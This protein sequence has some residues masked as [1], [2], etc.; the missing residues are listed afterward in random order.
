MCLHLH[1]LCDVIK[2]PSDI[3]IFFHIAEIEY[4]KNEPRNSKMCGHLHGCCD[5]ITEIRSFSEK[6]IEAGVR[7]PAF[8]GGYL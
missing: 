3:K 1:S 7:V 8:S 4:K 2:P 6:Y 5:V